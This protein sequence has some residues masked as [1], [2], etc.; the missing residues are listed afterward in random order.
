[1]FGASPKY[2]TTLLSFHCLIIF[3]IIVFILLT[4]L[5]LYLVFITY[6]RGSWLSLFLGFF[7]YIY[8]KKRNLKQ[9]VYALI[10][11]FLGTLGFL[12]TFNSEILLK[13]GDRGFLTKIAFDNLNIFRGLGP[14]NYVDSIYKDYFLETTN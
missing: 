10:F 4:L 2:K 7:I 3:L 1:M 12:N 14:G 8:L 5:N 9:L 6:S 11:I 13:E